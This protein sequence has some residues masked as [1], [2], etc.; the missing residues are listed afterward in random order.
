M[1]QINHSIWRSNWPGFYNMNSIMTTVQ[2]T[3]IDTWSENRPDSSVYKAPA[4]SQ[5]SPLFMDCIS[6][7]LETF[8]PQ[9]GRRERGRAP[10][11]ASIIGYEP[12]VV[13]WLA[14]IGAWKRYMQWPKVIA[15]YSWG[16]GSP[17]AGPGHN[18]GRG[19]GGEAPG[20]LWDFVI[21]KISK[22]LR[23]L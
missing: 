15:K 3:L 9:Q 7:T 8:R 16:P 21:S 19:L 11:R 13:F 2:H 23:I 1:Q 10:G 6:T 5:W 14:G 18:P 20:S 12:F 4:V 17:P 22:W